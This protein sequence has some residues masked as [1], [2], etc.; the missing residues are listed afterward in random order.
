MEDYARFALDDAAMSGAIKQMRHDLRASI[1]DAMH[2]SLVRSRDIVTDVGRDVSTAAELSRE[3]PRD[4]A[5]AACKR[6]SEALRTMAEYGKTLD[7]ALADALERL[8]YRGYELER[9]LCVTASAQDRMAK[10]RLYVLIT[11]ALCGGDWLATAEAA[12]RGGANGLQLREKGLPDAELVTRAIRLTTLCHDYGALCFINDRVDIAA[13]SG[14]DGVHLGQDDV[15]IAQARR[16][17]PAS[18]IIGLSTHTPQQVDAAVIAAPDYIAVGPVFSSNTKPQDHIA[19]LETLTHAKKSSALPL[20]A[21]GGITT[22]KADAVLT[23]ADCCLC[24]CSAVISE[25][26]AAQACRGFIRAIEAHQPP[27]TPDK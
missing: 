11:E 2:E 27:A 24:V 19:G 25:P 23:A 26:D 5:V 14:A 4:V 21:I 1:P 17:L 15:S 7:A 22:K 16:W 8:R 9:R 18:A 12:L 6:L 13:I 10:L 20:V 3:T